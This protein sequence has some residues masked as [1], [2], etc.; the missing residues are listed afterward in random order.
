MY[1][2]FG[3]DL[4]A[5]LKRIEQWI[6]GCAEALMNHAGCRLLKKAR[7][8]THPPLARQDAPCPKQG[9]RE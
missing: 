1:Q 3:E 5:D 4:K 8:H 7:L 2:L 6:D 9:R